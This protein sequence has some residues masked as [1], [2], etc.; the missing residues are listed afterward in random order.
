MFSATLI[1]GVM[2]INGLIL[3][4]MLGWRSTLAGWSAALLFGVLTIYLA[5]IWDEVVFDKLDQVLTGSV[6]CS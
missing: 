4:K 1:G 2:A 3:A 5:V 6:F